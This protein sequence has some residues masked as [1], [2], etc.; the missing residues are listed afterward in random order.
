MTRSNADLWSRLFLVFVSKLS[1]L[2]FLR[3]MPKTANSESSKQSIAFSSDDDLD[4]GLYYLRT[5]SNMFRWA[6]DAFYGVLAT[7]LIEEPNPSLSEISRW[8]LSYLRSHS[9]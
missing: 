3:T 5:L 2:N 6:P 9:C 7:R 8:F 4:M 1:Q